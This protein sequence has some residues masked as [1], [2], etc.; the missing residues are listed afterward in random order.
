MLIETVNLHITRRCNL[1]CRYCFGSCPE[2]PCAL[3]QPS[4]RL[5]LNELRRSGVRRVNFSGGEPTLH[6]GLLGMMQH[7]RRVGLSTSIITNTARLTDEMLGQLDI[8]GLSLDSRD[9]RVLT[10]LGRQRHGAPSYVER[11]RRA[12]ERTHAAGVRLKVNT[13]VTA[14]TLGRSAEVTHQCS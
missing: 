11:L 12:A 7:A 5:L 13:V 4:W 10:Q 2:H 8:V 9:E 14:L 3:D 1:R 6:P